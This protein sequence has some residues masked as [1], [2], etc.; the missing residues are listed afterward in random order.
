[1]K[2]KMQAPLESFKQLGFVIG[3][4]E[5]TV[6]NDTA[7]TS[8]SDEDAWIGMRHAFRIKWEDIK[9]KNAWE[10]V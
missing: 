9:R 8:L 10:R 5:V 6:F 4:Q 3:G 7:G 1:M 2:R